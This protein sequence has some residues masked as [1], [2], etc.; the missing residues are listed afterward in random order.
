MRQ[1]IDRTC[2]ERH[3][4]GRDEQDAE[5]DLR[6]VN[7]EI[8]GWD[9]YEDEAD[10]ARDH[11]KERSCPGLRLLLAAMPKPR[12]E[13]GGPER[14]SGQEDDQ[15]DALHAAIVGHKRMRLCWPT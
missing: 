4:H 7:D 8:H 5:G 1:P 6:V 11:A 9:Q 15:L 10:E 12:G 13:R 14:R 2:E 3:G